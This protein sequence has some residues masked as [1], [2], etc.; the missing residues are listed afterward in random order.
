MWKLLKIDRAIP[1]SNCSDQFDLAYKTLPDNQELYGRPTKMAAR[2]YMAKV[3][4]YQRKWD[5]CLNAC[6]EVIK[7]GK[8][9]LLPDFR[10]LF[11]PENDNCSEVIF[12]VQLSTIVR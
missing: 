5:E 4:L 6:D 10:N 8:Y 9:S 2:A 3:Y 11:L 1:L 7:S 12:A